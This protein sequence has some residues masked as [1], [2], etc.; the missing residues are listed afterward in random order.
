MAP[1]VISSDCSAHTH[2]S[3]IDWVGVTLWSVWS[4]CNRCIETRRFR[5]NSEISWM[6]N[7]IVAIIFIAI[8]EIINALTEEMLQKE[9]ANASKSSRAFSFLH[10]LDLNT[11]QRNHTICICRVDLRETT[12]ATQVV[13]LIVRIIW[14]VPEVVVALT[15]SIFSEIVHKCV[16]Q[17]RC[18]DESEREKHEEVECCR[19]WD[20]GQVSASFESQ[21]SHGENGRNA[22]RDSA[23]IQYK[24]FN[25]IIR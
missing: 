1:Y 20:F 13:L 8:V 5:S 23:W 21:E 16:L 24:S 15:R 17:N 2:T 25:K 6:M 7:R 10:N 3:L 19:I 12:H 18:K 11:W 4:S 14:I 9:Q 22:K